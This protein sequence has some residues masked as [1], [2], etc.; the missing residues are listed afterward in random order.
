M[1]FKFSQKVANLSNQLLS[2]TI[3]SSQY[4]DIR[5]QSW[6]HYEGSELIVGGSSFISITS[7]E[8]LL[9]L[10][11]L[12]GIY[13]IDLHDLKNADKCFEIASSYSRGLITEL[14][15]RI[16]IENTEYQGVASITSRE[17]RTQMIMNGTQQ[18]KL[19]PI[20]VA[21][22]WLVFRILL[23]ASL[24]CLSFSDPLFAVSFWRLFTARDDLVV[25]FPIAM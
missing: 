14:M 15:G 24:C 13:T 8:G 12:S 1:Y 18:M 20:I 21:I 11:S 6:T 17:W 5:V 23:L 9:L 22:L 16:T 7:I 3:I 2:F 4:T 10:L 19:L 25:M